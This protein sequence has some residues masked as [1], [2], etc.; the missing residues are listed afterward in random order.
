MKTAALLVL[1]LLLLGCEEEQPPAVEPVD[2][3]ATEEEAA[4]EG[5]AG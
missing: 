5:N 4:P 3:D 1:A 2:P